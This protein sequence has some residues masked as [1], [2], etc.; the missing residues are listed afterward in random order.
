MIADDLSSVLIAALYPCGVSAMPKKR[1]E[2]NQEREYKAFERGVILGI[3]LA[4]GERP[5]TN[6]VVDMLGYRSYQ[7]ANQAMSQLRVPGFNREED[8]GRWWLDVAAWLRW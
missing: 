6:E 3:R 4:L 2:R 5:T 7:G 8:T 1:R